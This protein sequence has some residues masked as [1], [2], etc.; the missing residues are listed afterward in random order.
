[1]RP[2]EHRLEIA[3]LLHANGFNCSAILSP[4][5]GA[6]PWADTLALY[7][8]HRFVLALHGF[9]RQD[10][11]IWE[12]LLAGA[13]P[14]IEHFSEQDELL[15]GLPIVRVKVWS[16]LTPT[17]LQAE[18]QRILHGVNS[19]KLSWTKVYLPY[20]LD[21]FTRHMHSPVASDVH[22]TSGMYNE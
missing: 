18:W 16:E 8:H 7:A 10:F 17:W 19:G 12:I 1:M 20:W 6:R 2:Y 14:V 22:I 15:D 5:G 3:R 9:G 4:G 11:R 21:R 13:V